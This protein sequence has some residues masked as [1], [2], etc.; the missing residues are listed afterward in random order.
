M[1]QVR[2]CGF[3]GQGIILA[4]TLLGYAGVKDTKWV[5]SS[6]SYGGSARGG[7]CRA[8]VIIADNQIIFPKI[9]KAD[10]LIAMCQDAYNAYIGNIEKQNGIVIY[11]AHLVSPKSID[12]LKQVSVPATS[13]ATK[14]LES[15]QV[16][17]IVILGA[18]VAI[19][20]IVSKESLVSSTRDNVPAKF[21]EIN[22]KAVDVGWSLV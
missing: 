15:A 12:G 2:L 7:A 1:K 3:G 14:R 6:S 10:I 21:R 4:G 5:A 9:T 16:A 18:S 19:T 8:D 22:L 11:D 13:I 20:G 17:T